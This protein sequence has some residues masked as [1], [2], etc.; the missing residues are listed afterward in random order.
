MPL[1]VTQKIKNISANNEAMLL[2][3]GRDVAPYK[4]Y[5]VVHILMLRWEHVRFQSPASSK[6]NVTICGCM[7]VDSDT[8][9]NKVLKGCVSTGA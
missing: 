8:P 3:L 5:Q 9:E 1:G 7:G 4:I 6:F 2:K